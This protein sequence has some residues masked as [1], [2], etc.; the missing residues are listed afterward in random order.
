MKGVI[1]GAAGLAVAGENITQKMRRITISLCNISL[2][3]LKQVYTKFM[4][5]LVM[6]ECVVKGDW[7]SR[8]RSKYK[9][10]NFQ[11]LTQ[12]QFHVIPCIMHRPLGPSNEMLR[13]ELVPL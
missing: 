13:I 6:V 11:G 8:L 3:L 7:L 5:I 2:D 1:V 4:A 9:L 10:S 12:P